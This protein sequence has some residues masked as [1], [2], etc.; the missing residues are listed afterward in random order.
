MQIPYGV[1]VPT[2]VVSPWVTPGKGPN[3]TLDHCSILK[4]ILARF[5]AAE[6]PFLSDRVASSHSFESFLTESQPRLD[7]PHTDPLTPLPETARLVRPGGSRIVTPPVTRKALREDTA[8]FHE[9]SGFVA[10][11]IGR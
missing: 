6:K 8:D 10:R 2:F 5:A 11:M 1:R 7:V 3:V 4:T 9:L